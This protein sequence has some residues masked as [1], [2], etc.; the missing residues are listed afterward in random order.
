MIAIAGPAN[1]RLEMMVTV[2]PA[3]NDAASDTVSD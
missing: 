2:A 1:G 3:A